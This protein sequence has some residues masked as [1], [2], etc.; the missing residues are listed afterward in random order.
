[1]SRTALPAAVLLLVGG[2]VAVQSGTPAV[3]A[4]TTLR[5][6]AAKAGL[7]FG[8]ASSPNRLYPILG[9]EFGQLTPE[10]DMKPDRIATSS[11]GLQN[12]SGA[13]QLVNHAQ[14][15][16]MLVRGHT[17]V[18]HSQAGA[19]QGASQATLNNFIGNAINRWGSKIAYWDVVNEALED[20]NTGR[21]RN[22]W[23]HTM[24]R[25]ANGDG[26]F[27]DAGDT[28]VIRDSFIRAKQVVQ[29]G[30]YS[31]KLCINDYDVEGLTVQGGGPNRKANA[32]YDIV[33]TYRQYIDCVGFQSHFND[34]PNSIIS[35][36][37]QANIQR[38]ADLGVE[39]HLSEVDIDD[40]LSNNDIG[41]GQADN[42]RKVVRACLNVAKCTGITVWG[43]S[44]SESWRSSER[45]LLFT[46][47]NG[48]YQKKAAYYAVLDELNK[49]RTTTPPTTTPP[50]T[51]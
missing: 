7:F 42:Y 50:P 47:G 8:T 23:P 48:N 17:L 44:D 1:M 25:D 32:L 39:V 4:E 18:W 11:G 19:L 41:A 20:N 49:G 33:R 6:A 43:I 36:D 16:G 26:D 29:A 51:T 9:Q 37:L 45:G 40:D 5:A 28:D 24:N 13:D 21:R 35:N 38:F 31:T 27:F 10:N 22:Q 46:G 3:A 12:T 14:S 30:G 34:N 15:N 2:A